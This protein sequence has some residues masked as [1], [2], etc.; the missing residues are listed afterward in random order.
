MAGFG[1]RQKVGRLEKEVLINSHG[2]EIGDFPRKFQ[3]RRAAPVNEPAVG[4]DF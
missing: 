2:L 1:G 4:S 3:L